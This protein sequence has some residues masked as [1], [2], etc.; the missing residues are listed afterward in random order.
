M[1]LQP[2]NGVEEVNIFKSDGTV[3]NIP[4][5]KIQASY[6][7]NTYVISGPAQT[8]QLTEMLPNILNQLG[9]ESLERLRSYADTIQNNWGPG[10]EQEEEVDDDD[11]VPELVENFEDASN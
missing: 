11:D 4:L 10:P 2:M 9:P 8:K 6:P 1:A 3:I 7:S 5:P